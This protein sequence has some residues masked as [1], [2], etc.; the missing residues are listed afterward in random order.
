MVRPYFDG[1]WLG[2][3]VSVPA[4]RSLSTLVGLLTEIGGG[5]SDSWNYIRTATGAVGETDLEVDLSF[6]P[7]MTG[8]RGRIANI[9]EENLSVGHLFVAAFRSM[10]ENYAAMFESSFAG[11]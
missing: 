7:C 1:N 6:F 3:I 9:R 5:D 4:G 11:M 8:D 10:A 2:T